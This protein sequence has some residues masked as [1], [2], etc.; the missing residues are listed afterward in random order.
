MKK[1]AMTEEIMIASKIGLEVKVVE[2]GMVEFMGV[3]K[4]REAEWPI[5][6]SNYQN[7]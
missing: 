4:R 7:F 5:I 2:A 3:M 6:T 1:M